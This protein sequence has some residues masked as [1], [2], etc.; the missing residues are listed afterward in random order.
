MKLFHIQIGLFICRINH[1]MSP[2][3]CA[4]DGLGVGV[5]IS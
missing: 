1:L 2:H 5:D 4:D 3:L